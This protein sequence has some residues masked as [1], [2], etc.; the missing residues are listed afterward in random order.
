VLQY[1]QEAPE[2]SKKGR[3]KMKT[4]EEMLIMIGN[5]F[6]DAYIAGGRKDS[7]SFTRVRAQRDKIYDAVVE[8]Y[9]ELEHESYEREQI[10]V[11][12]NKANKRIEGLQRD[13]NDMR[14]VKDRLLLFIR[15][16][17]ERLQEDD[18]PAPDD[19]E[20]ELRDCLPFPDVE[21]MAPA[22]DVEGRCE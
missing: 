12:L 5:L 22:S 11:E 13:Y 3:K 10:Q 14:D 7:E 16:K 19:M 1:Q 15:E 21:D 8:L 18:A 17:D 9:A 6:F 4:R 2:A 20:P